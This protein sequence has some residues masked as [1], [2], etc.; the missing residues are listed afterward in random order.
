MSGVGPCSNL[1]KSS[2]LYTINNFSLVTRPQTPQTNKSSSL[3]ENVLDVVKCF[4]LVWNSPIS[5][6]VIYFFF[7]N[8]YDIFQFHSKLIVHYDN[9]EIGTSY[10]LKKVQMQF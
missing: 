8:Y 7:C 3:F 2:S 4:N 10:Q 1:F 5:S 9:L 6:A